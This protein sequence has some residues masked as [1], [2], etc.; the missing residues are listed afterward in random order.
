MFVNTTKMTTEVDL[1]A[2]GK[3]LEAYGSG[4]YK[5]R[6]IQIW[7]VQGQN[8]TDLGCKRLEAYG[9]EL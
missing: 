7:A 9:S 5:V 4:L 3:R 2:C 1:E 8:H 6:I